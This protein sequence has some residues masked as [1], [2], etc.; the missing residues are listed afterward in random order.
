MNEKQF[1]DF[2]INLGYTLHENG[3]TWMKSPK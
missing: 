1:A 2:M 3:S